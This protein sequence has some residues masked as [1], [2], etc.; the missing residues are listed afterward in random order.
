M[1]RTGQCH[2]GSLRVI[3]T[4]EPDRV[5]LSHCQAC[6]RRTGTAFHFGATFPKEQVQLD[7]ERKNGASERLLLHG[8]TDSSNLL[9][10]S[11]ESSA[12]LTFSLGVRH[13]VCFGP[14]QFPVGQ[15]YSTPHDVD[16]CAAFGVRQQGV[17]RSDVLNTH[18]T[19]K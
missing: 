17:G 3:T 15:S 5:Y 14:A 1:Q 2:C 9:S 13:H 12:N 10:S 4:G 7:G 6:Q 18:R 16:V 19:N 8:G 11:G